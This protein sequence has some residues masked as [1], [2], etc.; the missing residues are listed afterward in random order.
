[1]IPHLR[2]LALLVLALFLAGC[3]T[4]S[5]SNSGYV[6]TDPSF[7]Y[8]VSDRPNPA[9]HGELSEL[10]VLG[11]SPNKQITEGDIH[12]ALTDAAKISLKKGDKIVLVQSG[13]QYPDDGMVQQLKPYLDVMPVS[14]VPS[15]PPKPGTFEATQRQPIDLTL[16]LAAARAG[17]RTL[18]VYWG[19][20]ESSVEGNVGKTLSWVPIVGLV[21]P[22]QSEH[23]RIRLKAAIID[24]DSGHWE[25][26][27]PDAVDNSGLSAQ[28]ARR[29]VDQKQV[30]ELKDEGYKRLGIEIVKLMG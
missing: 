26:L 2:R 27:T 24:V 30:E 14:G 16:R 3:E 9:Y 15:T 29:H 1:M 11:I 28:V 23:M 10:D 25:M 20:L 21:V 13:A 17:A 8:D 18:I 19:I 4:R 7:P 12:A 22:D 5:I 6:S